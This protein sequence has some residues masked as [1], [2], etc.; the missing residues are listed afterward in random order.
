VVGAF[1]RLIKPHVLLRI[2]MV[3]LHFSLLPRWRGAAPVER[4]L[5]AGDEVTG[6]CVMEVAEGL[7]TGDVYAV[8][9]VDIESRDTL[10]SLRARL[11]EIGARLL[12]DS[13]SAGLAQP[14][15]QVG[16]E[17]YAAKIDPAELRIDW[18]RPAADLDRLVRLGGA[19]TTLDGRRLKVIDAEPV[20]AGLTPGSVDG[21][22]VGAGSGALRLL[23]VQ[24]EGKGSMAWQAFANGARLES[25]ATLGA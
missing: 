5:L 17:V 15:P 7:D 22:V 1:G 14:L 16:D 18:S 20:D 8:E 6:V 10:A 23:T 9:E 19:W 24:P 21:S 13:L 12:V 2:P 11:V 25:G 4:A 3:N